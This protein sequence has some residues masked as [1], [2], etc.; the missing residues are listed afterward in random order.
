MP[1]MGAESEVCIGKDRELI[2]EWE[3]TQNDEEKVSN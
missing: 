2:S 1:G 3:I